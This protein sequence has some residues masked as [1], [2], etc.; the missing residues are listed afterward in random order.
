[1][2][3][4]NNNDPG[5]ETSIYTPLRIFSYWMEIEIMKF[6]HLPL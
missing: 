3:I 1:M 2:N 6:N 4:N 5:Y